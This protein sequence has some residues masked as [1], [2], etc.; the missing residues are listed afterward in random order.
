[1]AERARTAGVQVVFVAPPVEAGQR[2]GQCGGEFGA[3]L[4]QLA[5]LGGE[6]VLDYGCLELP[7][8]FFI[9]QGHM[10]ARGRAWFTASLKAELDALQ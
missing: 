3:L 2:E 10:G 6:A 4:A 1:M 8:D 9:N 7:A 5:L